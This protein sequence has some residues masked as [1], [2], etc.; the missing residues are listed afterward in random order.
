MELCT[1]LFYDTTYEKIELCM[2]LQVKSADLKVLLSGRSKQTSKHTH[3]WAQW[4]YASVGLAQAH[5]KY[6]FQP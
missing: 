4:N 5:P 3:A 2:H 6:F 1:E